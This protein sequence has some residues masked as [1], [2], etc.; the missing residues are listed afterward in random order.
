L[1]A[2]N[3]DFA[4]LGLLWRFF[5]FWVRLWRRLVNRR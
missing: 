1:K 3:L 2:I 4:A 5:L